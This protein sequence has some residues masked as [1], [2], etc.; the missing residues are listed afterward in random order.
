MSPREGTA[1]DEIWLGDVANAT[2]PTCSLKDRVGEIR[3]EVLAAGWDTCVVVNVQRVVLGVL[4][5]KALDGD[6]DAT[7]EKGMHSGPSTFR[8]DVTLD[9]QLKF[10]RD[11][12]IKTNS[13][14]T[15]LGGKLI[16]VLS[17]DDAEA[18]AARESQAAGQLAASRGGS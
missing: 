12:N 1:K 10:M 13:L 14:V 5:K 7:A 8:P 3:D 18:A 17:R 11:R 15:T 16:G 9:A 4:R 6:P 2:V